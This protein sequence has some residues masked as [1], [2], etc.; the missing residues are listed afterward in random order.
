MKAEYQEMLKDVIEMF[1]LCTIYDK[2][3]GEWP[4]SDKEFER[5]WDIFYKLIESGDTDVLRGLMGLLTM[6]VE[7]GG[8]LD[9]SLVDGIASYYTPEQITEA[10]FDKFDAIYDNDGGPDDKFG[11]ADILEIICSDLWS[12]EWKGR[13]DGRGFSRF[14][15]MFNKV[16]PR[17]AERFLNEMEKYKVEEEKP[18]IQALREDMKQ[19]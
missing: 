14:R 12:P 18:M 6:K 11:M 9:E 5:R 10:I 8:A 15:E 13:E 4:F 19:W 7:G 16:R 17:H 3:E 2:G 1:L